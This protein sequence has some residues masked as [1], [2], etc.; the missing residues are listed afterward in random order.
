MALVARQKMLRASAE[1]SLEFSTTTAAGAGKDGISGK[2]PFYH[3]Y[4]T[5]SFIAMLCSV[6]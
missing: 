6:I 1:E 3:I 5:S 4:T 2:N